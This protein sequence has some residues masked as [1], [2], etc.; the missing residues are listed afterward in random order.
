VRG[1]VLV[2]APSAPALAGRAPRAAAPALS[3]VDLRVAQ[4]A[5]C[6]TRPPRWPSALRAPLLYRE[7]S[8]L[9]LP[10]FS[11]LLY[12]IYFTPRFDCAEL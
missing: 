9:A 8:V 6:P 2:D 1:F 5:L 3:A 11:H 7:V 10:L 12:S 4:V